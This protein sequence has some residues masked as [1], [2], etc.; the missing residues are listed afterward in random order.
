L[1]IRLRFLP[2][3][4]VATLIIVA[5]F[6]IPTAKAAPPEKDLTLNS[7]QF[8]GDTINLG[9]M[10]LDGQGPYNLPYNTRVSV[11][12]HRIRFIP[13]AGFYLLGWGTSPDKLFAD[14]TEFAAEKDTEK[15]LEASKD[16]PTVT[17]I[18]QKIGQPA[19]VGGVVLPTNTCPILT[20]YLAMIGL[21]ATTAA[22]VVKKRRN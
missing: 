22:V 14:L 21:I 12:T 1:S 20:P 11:G 19:Y 3:L 4:L 9:Q 18:Y 5:G 7:R 10:Y 15:L 16:D 13:P 2:F 8:N 6:S 17:A